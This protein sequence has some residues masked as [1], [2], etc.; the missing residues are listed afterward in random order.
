MIWGGLIIIKTLTLYAKKQPTKKGFNKMIEENFTV[1]LAV[2][3]LAIP[4]AHHIITTAIRNK[5]RG[6]SPPIKSK[7]V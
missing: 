1:I 7:P 6:I 5:S 4:L 3:A 2:V